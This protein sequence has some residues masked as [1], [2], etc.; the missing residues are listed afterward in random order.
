MNLL[1]VC[2]PS[3]C[4]VAALLPCLDIIS[5]LA[6]TRAHH[7]VAE[8]LAIIDIVTHGVEDQIGL[9]SSVR[10]LPATAIRLL[11]SSHT[12]ITQTANY[13]RKGKKQI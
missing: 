2:T 5:I 10:A 6:E 3:A 12:A 4:S 7:S 9:A 8:R 13:G 1:K 11:G